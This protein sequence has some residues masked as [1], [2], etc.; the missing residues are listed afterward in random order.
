MKKIFS[1]VRKKHISLRVNILTL[2]LL[3]ICSAFVFVMTYTYVRTMKTIRS[4]SE[5]EVERVSRLILNKVGDLT[6]SVQSMVQTGAGYLPSLGE[7]SIENKELILYLL[8]QIKYDPNVTN[9]YIGTRDKLFLGAYDQKISLQ[10]Y[11]LTDPTVL[12]PKE[13]QFAVGYVNHKVEPPIETWYYLDDDFKVVMSEDV[14]NSTYDVLERPWYIDALKTEK[15]TWSEVY[16]FY[17][18]QGLGMTAT[19][20]VFD[21]A[22][23]IEDVVGGDLSFAFLS[24]FVAKQRVTRLGRAFFLDSQGEIV[25]PHVEEEGHDLTFP[26]ETVSLAFN[27]Y[28]ET[29]DPIFTMR[30][31][32][33]DY[34]I[35][36]APL[37]SIFET[38]MVIMII[39]PAKTFT[40]PFVQTLKHTS[41]VLLVILTIS[42]FLI[43]Y[44][45]R[46]ISQPII[47][48]SHEIDK[49]SQLDL[50]PSPEVHS[51]IKEINLMKS[52]V[53]SLR[54]E[55]DSFMRY[56]PKEVVRQLIDQGGAVTLGGDKKEITIL[57][58]DI[59]NFSTIAE[60]HTAEEVMHF[61]ADYFDPL[62]L[63]ILSREGIID[64]YI[65]DGLMA[66]WGAPRDV[67]NHAE[68]ACIATLYCK[69]AV[70]EL[71]EKFKKEGKPQL[72]TRF[73]VNTGV[74]IVGNIGSAERMNYTAMGDAVNTA[75]RLEGVNKTYHTSIIISEEV[76]KRIGD[77]FL[78]RYL[79]T[80]TVKG[81]TEQ[82]KIFELIA[83]YDPDLSIHATEK[84]IEFA[85]AFTQAVEILES[86]EKEKAKSAFEA[87]QKSHPEDYPTKYYLERL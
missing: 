55:V 77:H 84:Q 33:E 83:I 40:A 25:L 70:V 82:I 86:G 24:D 73:G 28:R 47:A 5:V 65:G 61:L 72:I 9:L 19:V 31:D 36:V 79:G 52:S 12:I 41:F 35:Q 75:A 62:T 49:I 11:L 69:K 76:K 32:R 71:N 66:F 13:A 8:N 14:P 7:I 81:K 68:Q 42:I 17:P 16:T 37:Q 44:L 53:V 18:S 1:H 60:Q 78:T 38:D 67:E 3:L 54:L 10:N 64:K 56:V 34:L 87:L 15:L 27:Q 43:L 45:S 57:F 51:Q 23:E 50:T 6:G 20:P 30:V 59:E 21:Q 46:R 29:K 58:S 26:K 85:A 74:S 63:I 4:F 48:L 80:T 22:R 39:V 2:F